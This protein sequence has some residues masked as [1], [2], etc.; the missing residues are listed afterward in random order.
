MKQRKMFLINQKKTLNLS[1]I[2]LIYHQRKMKT[3]TWSKLILSNIRIIQKLSGENELSKLNEFC[4]GDK[5]KSS[6]FYK[7]LIVQVIFI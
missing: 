6:I 2:K 5:L 1:Q 7:I 4:K 3:F